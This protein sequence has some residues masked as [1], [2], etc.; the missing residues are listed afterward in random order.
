MYFNIIPYVWAETSFL[1][2]EI[3]HIKYLIEIGDEW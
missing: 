1:I 2:D 3:Q